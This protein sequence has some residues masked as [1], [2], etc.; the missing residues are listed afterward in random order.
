MVGDIV[1]QVIIFVGIAA[2][3]VCFMFGGNQNWGE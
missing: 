2:N 3:L 1:W